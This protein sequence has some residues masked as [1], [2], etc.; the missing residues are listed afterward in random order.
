VR[1]RA[2]ELDD[3]CGVRPNVVFDLEDGEGIVVQAGLEPL[4][5]AGGAVFER[6]FLVG[7]VGGRVNGCVELEGDAAG[8]EGP[9]AQ[10]LAG[11]A[12]PADQPPANNRLVVASRRPAA[13]AAPVTPSI[14]RRRFRFP[15]G[16][17]AIRSSCAKFS[18]AYR[19]RLVQ[20][21][22]SHPRSR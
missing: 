7:G 6:A 20:S 15:T 8:E 16:S 14:A 11:G 21:I 5:E 13:S 19:A 2:G 10:V 1:D 4:A 3:G 18:G 12:A 17:C 22:S 9:G